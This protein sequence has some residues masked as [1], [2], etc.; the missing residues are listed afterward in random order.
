LPSLPRTDEPILLY[1]PLGVA[2]FN[3][4]SYRTTDLLDAS[5][6]LS[7]DCLFFESSI[8]PLH[9]PVGLGLPQ[10]GETGLMPQNLTRLTKW[11]DIY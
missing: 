8:D 9:N 1:P 7:I 4:L 5:E 10:E 2:I 6:D 11:S 3:K